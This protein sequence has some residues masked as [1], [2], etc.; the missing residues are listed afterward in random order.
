MLLYVRTGNST[1]YLQI[2]VPHYFAFWPNMTIAAGGKV[3]VINDV[4]IPLQITFLVVLVLVIRV[5][6]MV[7][8]VVV[9]V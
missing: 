7:I 2:Y 8:V 9:L 4:F 1:G 5:L 6:F 3:D